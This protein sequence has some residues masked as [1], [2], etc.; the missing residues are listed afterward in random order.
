ML[1][2]IVTTV[3]TVLDNSPDWADRAY[4]KLG[5]LYSKLF[6]D[7]GNSKKI[8][9]PMF[10]ALKTALT[11]LILRKLLHMTQAQLQTFQFEGL[12]RYF[13]SICFFFWLLDQVS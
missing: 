11:S 7:E 10:P 8:S 3:H 4:H 6:L 2:L 9:K 13:F 12:V 1:R 5:H